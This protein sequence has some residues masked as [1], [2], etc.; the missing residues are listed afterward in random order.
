MHGHLTEFVTVAPYSIGGSYYQLLLDT[1]SGEFM[2]V[3]PV[4]F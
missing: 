2:N 4:T 3:Y 1:K